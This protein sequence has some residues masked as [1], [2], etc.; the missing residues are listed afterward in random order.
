MCRVKVGGSEACES[1]KRYNASPTN[2][3]NSKRGPC[4]IGC[5]EQTVFVQMW[6]M[7]NDV[8]VSCRE[9]LSFIGHKF[10]RVL[11]SIMRIN[12]FS[13]VRP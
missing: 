13:T 12:D 2:V 1:K 8:A 5:D 4:Y 11:F 9:A 6:I 7:R 10:R 3:H